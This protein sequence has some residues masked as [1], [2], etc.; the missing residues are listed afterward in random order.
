MGTAKAVSV[1]GISI[2]GVD[3]GNYTYNT[4]ASTTADVTAKSL[5]ASFTASSKVY[6]GSTSAAVSGCALTGVVS[7]DDVSC[8]ASNGQFDNASVGAG[9]TVTADVALS[10]ADSG[11]Y[12]VA[13]TATST[14]DITK[15]SL[16]VTGITA[17]DK[18]YD[19]TTAATL[20]VAGAALVGVVSGDTVT[21]DTSAAVGTFSDKNVGAGKTVQVSGLTIGG[22]N[23]GD[24]MLTQPTATASITQLY[25]TVSG[26]H[27]GQ[28]DLRREHVG[29]AEHEPGGAERGDLSGRRDARR[30]RR[31]GSV[32]EQDGRHGQDG[33]GVGSDDRRGGRGQLRADAADGDCGHHGEAVDGELHGS[34]QGLRRIGFGVG[35]RRH[36]LTGVVGGDDVTLSGSPSATFA[37]KNVPGGT[38]TVTGV[39]LAGADAGNY[40]LFAP[41]TTSA[42]ITPRALAVTATG[43]SRTY[44]GTTAATVTLSDD[45]IG[46][47][48]FTA[49]Y[50]SA[51]FADKNVGTAKSVSVSGISI[52]GADA[53]NYTAN[54][55]ASAT[56]NITAKSLT[57]SAAG[58]NKVYD[59]LT[60][61]TVTLSDDRVSGDVVTDNYTSASFATR[62]VG[63]GIA[64][65]VSGISISGTDS[66]NY[67]LTSTTASATADITG[68]PLTIS[69]VGI[70]KVYDGTTTATVG[71]TDNRVSGRRVHGQL[72]ERELLGQE[73]GDG[74]G[75]ERLR[76]LD[77]GCGRGQLHVQHDG[78]DDGGHHGEVAD[79][80]DRGFEQDL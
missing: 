51:S 68:R 54:T 25:L 20:N 61:A 14:A 1:S 5:T 39:S 42:A 76:D 24:Y 71:L 7:P 10:G 80:D 35:D 47:D 46:S 72:R 31:F 16:T 58:V 73:R 69:A 75:G 59:G 45:R 11:N 33:P 52:S 53:V 29:D 41:I 17:S 28:Q 77:L 13:A 65:S 70:G 9:K 49:S 74:Q 22:A 67:S 38:V 43:V 4:T 63:T 15:A 19:Q 3:A 26:H 8:A 48:S 18:V 50:G 78:G 79:G 32:R 34:G 6:D 21:L 55:T 2:S 64:V 56:A 62:N 12:S 27:G 44:D 66:G 37:S 36:A 60:S 40:T 23:A 30:E 57:V